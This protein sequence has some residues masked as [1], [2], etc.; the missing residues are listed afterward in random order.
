LAWAIYLKRGSN[1][2]FLSGIARSY[3]RGVEGRAIQMMCARIGFATGRGLAGALR[4][5]PPWLVALAALG[6]LIANTI[7][8]GADL[9]GMADAAEMLTGLNS[10]Y[11]VVH[12]GVA[13]A[14]GTVLFRVGLDR[15][16]PERVHDFE[17]NGSSGYSPF[18]GSEG[19]RLLL[20]VVL[21]AGVYWYCVPNCRALRAS[22]LAPFP[23][24][25]G[26][27]R[28]VAQAWW[29]IG[30]REKFWAQSKPQSKYGNRNTNWTNTGIPGGK[31]LRPNTELQWLGLCPQWNAR[32]SRV[33]GENRAEF[34]Y[35]LRHDPQFRSVRSEHLVEAGKRVR[36]KDDVKIFAEVLRGNLEG[37][38]FQFYVISASPREVVQSALEG[39]VP[40]ENVF[41][42]EF[43]YDP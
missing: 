1:H 8:V 23:S 32:D 22:D 25:P 41:G 11:Y 9:S 40:P 42:T 14:L 43:G 31:W 29:L 27:S 16:A 7:T 38:R 28:A 2:Q 36:L 30:F 21:G 10:H 35:L 24:W 5:K 26:R 20:C 17:R 3:D 13:I 6:L 33:P 34:A 15:F 18:H 12:F 37:N 4:E 39:I 19:F